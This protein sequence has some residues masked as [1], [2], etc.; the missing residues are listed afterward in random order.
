MSGR[1]VIRGLALA[2]LLLVANGA[3]AS[4]WQ[5][6]VAPGAVVEH[7]QKYEQECDKCH[8]QFDKA[9]QRRLCLACHE[10]IAADVEAGRGYHGRN[11]QA[12]TGECRHCH[13]DHK[14]RT[15]D[16]VRLDPQTFDHRL[17]DMPLT[18]RH[19]QVPCAACHVPGKRHAEAPD[20]CADCHDKDDPHRGKLGRACADCHDTGGWGKTGFDHA[21]TRF[22][23]EGR[24]RD[25]ACG[26]CHPDRRYKPTP[27]A[28]AACHRLNDVHAGAY[29]DR[30]DTCHNAADWHKAVFNHDRQT[31]FRL[32]GR[33]RTAR[34]DACHKGGS[35]NTRL[36][37]ACIDCHKADDFHRGRFGTRCQ[38]C[39]DERAWKQT[40]FDHA[41]D[42]KLEL[43]GRHASLQCVACHRD[44]AGKPAVA[45]TCHSCHAERDIHKG[46]LGKACDRCHDEDD[47]IHV[48]FDHGLARF[49]LVG[50]HAVVPCEECHA[51]GRFKDAPSACV[52]CHRPKDVHKGAL[53]TACGECHNPN[54]WRLWRFDHARQT[55][56]AL[57][58]AHEGLACEACH[59]RNKAPGKLPTDCNACHARDDVHDGRFGLVCERCHDTTRFRDVK[60][61]GF[62]R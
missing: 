53:G 58:G 11:A 2:G 43:K 56:F 9:N 44:G 50:L 10:R 27:T 18:G 61:S 16:I 14:G 17:T 24:H 37:T 19:V 6:L 28:C 60:P 20:T 55:K 29:G 47:W 21:S 51:S 4:P 38:E 5:R 15:E 41:R 52:D 46:E 32:A 22:A 13:T 36:G 35:L 39:H 59:P 7:H 45:R 33:H 25:V 8:E 48:R 3:G 62:G 42:A 12:R 40:A 34:C 49:P 57:D 30:C 26:Q 1:K 23:L 54:D 31:K